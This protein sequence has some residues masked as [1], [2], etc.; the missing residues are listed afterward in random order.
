VLLDTARAQ[1]GD[2]LETIGVFDLYRGEHVPA[3]MVGV[4]LRLR[5]RATDRTLTDVEADTVVADLL[6]RWQTTHAVTLRR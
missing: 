2:L 3:G 4:G 1:A 5:L 6:A